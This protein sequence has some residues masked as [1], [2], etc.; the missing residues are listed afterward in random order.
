VI[1]R[2]GQPVV[3]GEACPSNPPPP[4]GYVVWKGPVPQELTQW[5]IALRDRIASYPY[6]QTFTMI[7][8]GTPVLARKDHHS[9]TNRPGPD[10]VV[11]LV[12]GICLAGITLY[13]PSSPS[14]GLSAADVTDPALATPD[15]DLALYSV[16]MTRP[17][18]HTDWGLVLVCAAALATVSGGFVWGIRAA[19]R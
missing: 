19:G 16:S 18:E 9:W 17:P 2:N 6:G 12:T 3:F 7:W 1:Y 11:R 8:S 10:G 14:S 5:A 15:P 4:A 13:K